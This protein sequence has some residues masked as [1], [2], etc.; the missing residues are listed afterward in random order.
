MGIV[1]VTVMLV[2]GRM[3][4]SGVMSL[5]EFFQYS[6]YMGFLIAPVFQVVGI[7]SQLT[8]SFAG[9]DRMHEVLAE[10]P[11]DIDPDRVKEIGEINGHVTFENVDFEYAKRAKL[12]TP[13]YLSRRRSGDGHR[14]GWI[15]RLR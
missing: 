13:Q 1:T 5:G 14:I 11:E 8:E 6:L 2:G 7:A 15:V 3:M 10:T 9:L 12:R 4:G